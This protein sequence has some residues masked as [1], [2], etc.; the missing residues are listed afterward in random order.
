MSSILTLESLRPN[1]NERIMDAVATA[2]IDVAPWARKANGELVKNPAANPNYC[3]EWAFGGDGLPTALC[4]W[5]DNLREVGG[6]I[7]CENNLRDLALRLDAVAEDRFGDPEVASRSKTQAKRARRFDLK[8]Q[9]AYRRHEEVRLIL[10]AGTQRDLNRLGYDASEVEY[11]RLDDAPWTVESYDDRT[12]AF[13]LVRKADSYKLTDEKRAYEQVAG[14]TV[15]QFADVFCDIDLQLSPAQREMLVG[16]SMAPGRTL[17]MERIAALG[18]YDYATANIE[19]GKLAGMIAGA[20]QIVGLANKMHAF[21]E[22][23]E[24]ADEHGHAQ[25]KMREPV[26]DALVRVGVAASNDT[27]HGLLETSLMNSEELAGEMPTTRKALIDARLGQGSYRKKML[28][29]W[30]GAC[31]LTGCAV[32]E[33][34]V[35]SHAV[36]WRLSSPRERLDHFNGLLL[37]GTF[38]RLFDGGL[39]GFAS[40]GSLVVSPRLSVQDRALLGLTEGMKLRRTCERLIGY[41]D[42]HRTLHGL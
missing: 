35:A 12:G 9:H 22:L 42:R 41:L 17:S 30:S 33:V 27:R 23:A 6:L 40:D 11:R 38:D 26:V 24:R 34:L 15:D 7:S 37:T 21:C 2:G 13:R 19:Y 16:H 39:I 18:G 31:A 32:D 4:V 29:W 1:S 20:L 5:Y 25:W 28:R 10:L 14:I 8:L 36:P 3:Y